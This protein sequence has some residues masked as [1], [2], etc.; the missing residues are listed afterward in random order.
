[1]IEIE[2]HTISVMTDMIVDVTMIERTIN[3]T[4]LKMIIGAMIDVMMKSDTT[5]ENMIVKSITNVAYL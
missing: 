1:M 3:D 5:V 2:S 4:A